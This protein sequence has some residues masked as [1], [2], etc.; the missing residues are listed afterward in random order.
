MDALELYGRIPA[1][2]WLGVEW[3]RV[4]IRAPLPPSAAFP[5]PQPA[6]GGPLVTR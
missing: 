3:A 1:G 4:R 6:E 2:R 5:M